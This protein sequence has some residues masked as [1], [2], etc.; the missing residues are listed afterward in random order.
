MTITGTTRRIQLKCLATPAA[1]QY[2]AGTAFHAYA[3]N[4]STQTTVHNAFPSKDIYFTEITGGNWATN[5]ADNIVWNFQNI[6]IG[7]TRNWAKTALLWNLA[8]DQNGGPHLNGCDGCRGVVTINNS[9]GAITFNEEFY[10]LGQMTKVVQPNAVRIDSTTTS[11][12]NTV[13]FLNPD[14]TR[15]LIALNPNASATTIRVLE[16]GKH[17]NY[18]IPAK[19]VMSFLWNDKGADF[20]NGGF[21]DGGFQSGGGSLDAWNT[22]GN[23]SGN[24]SAA[25]DALLSGDKSLKLSGQFSAGANT[26]GVFQGITVSPGDKLQASASALVQSIENLANTSNLAQMKFEYYSQY[27]AAYGS[28][29]FLGETQVTVADSSTTSDTWITRQLTGIAPAGATEARLVLQ[30]LQPNG[31]TGAVHFDNVA[32]GIVD[33]LP[34]AGDYNHDG[35]VDAADYDVWKSN[36]GSTINLAADGNNNGVVDATD[37]VVWRLN[38]G[39]TLAGAGASALAN[40]PEPGG[41]TIAFCAAFGAMAFQIRRV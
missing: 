13:A 35:S 4:V 27:G 24:V 26:S 29:S 19:S 6:F 39:A 32:F 36:F 41:L 23:T 22:F 1:S 30:F 14:G 8:L 7:G 18:A 37:Y 15:A 38:I 10:A 40:V 2:V 21:D 34:L 17:F 11:A 16:N 5:F 20:D 25:S 12:V 3:G 9:T 31:Q 28:A 33:Q